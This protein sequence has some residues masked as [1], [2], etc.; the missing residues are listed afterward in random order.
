MCFDIAFEQLAAGADAVDYLGHDP[1]VL[2][3]KSGQQV[4]RLN[5]AVIHLF[6]QILAVKRR[7]LRLLCEVI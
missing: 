2:G 6:G 5:L 1:I 4:Y 7:F 3:Q